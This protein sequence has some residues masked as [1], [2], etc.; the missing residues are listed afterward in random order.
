[1]IQERIGSGK[2]TGQMNL[3]DFNCFAEE[4]CVQKP[5]AKMEY[6]GDLKFLFAMPCFLAFPFLCKYSTSFSAQRW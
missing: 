1:M 6:L 2:N 3:P 5:F 4:L